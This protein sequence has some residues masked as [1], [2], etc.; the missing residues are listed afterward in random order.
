ML[1][2]VL[3]FGWMESE[4]NLTVL[5]KASHVNPPKTHSILPPALHT[6]EGSLLASQSLQLLPL[7]SPGILTLLCHLGSPGILILL[8][9]R[10]QAERGCQGSAQ[11][12]QAAGEQGR[13]EG[14]SR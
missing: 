3:P 4:V 5:C 11:P 12:L 1:R 8:C 2:H 7:G 6:G 14:G 10:L 9:H 13:R